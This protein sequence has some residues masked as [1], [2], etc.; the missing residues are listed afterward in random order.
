MQIFKIR[1]YLS[2]GVSIILLSITVSSNVVSK[3]VLNKISLST[4]NNLATN[5]FKEIN[6]YLPN[7][8]NSRE[9]NCHLQWLNAIWEFKNNGLEKSGLI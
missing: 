3:F 7:Q 2:I 5:N 6:T 4:F 1:N 9:I 8:T